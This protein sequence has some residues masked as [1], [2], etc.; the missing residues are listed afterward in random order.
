M[1]GTRGEGWRESARK[2]EALNQKRMQNPMQ[3]LPNRLTAV[4]KAHSMRAKSDEGK[5][6]RNE[7]VVGQDPIRD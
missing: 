3:T 2:L 1:A 4:D 6:N 5:P 7:D